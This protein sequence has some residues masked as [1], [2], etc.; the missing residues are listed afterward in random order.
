MNITLVQSRDHSKET[1]QLVTRSHPGSFVGVS[2]L[3][4]LN[5]QFQGDNTVSPGVVIRSLYALEPF[6]KFEYF[7]LYLLLTLNCISN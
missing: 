7:S 6:Q 5:Y 2:V 3:R 4:L 1:V